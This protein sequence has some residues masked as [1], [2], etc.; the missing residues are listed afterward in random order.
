RD[1]NVSMASKSLIQL[2]RVVNPALLKKKDRGKPTE[3]IDEQK[4]YKYAELKALNYIAGAEV[5]NEAI[6]EN[7][8]SGDEDES[9]EEEDDSDDEWVDVS[10]SED[11]LE[12]EQQQEGEDDEVPLDSIDKARFISS[13]RILT[14]E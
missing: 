12:L 9:E 4:V 2:Y 11:E 1:K 3:A 14:Q 5:L 7:D 8:E 13:E 6:P 10:H